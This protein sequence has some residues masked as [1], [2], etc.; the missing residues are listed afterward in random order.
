MIGVLRTI[1]A[2]AGAILSLLLI[3][4]GLTGSLLVFEND[5]IAE[6]IANGSVRETVRWRT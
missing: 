2:W 4:L 6:Q 3:V 1:H 5:W